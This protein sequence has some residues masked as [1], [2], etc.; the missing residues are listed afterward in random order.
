[1]SVLELG[2]NFLP[3]SYPEDDHNMEGDITEG[4]EHIQSQ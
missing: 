4:F 3:A 2:K 1:M